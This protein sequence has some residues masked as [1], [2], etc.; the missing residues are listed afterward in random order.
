MGMGLIGVGRKKADGA[1]VGFS[2]SSETE[3]QRNNTNEQIKAADEAAKQQQ[4]GTMTATGA[5]AGAYAG[6]QA[7]S[8]G[9]F[10][11]MAIGAAAGYLFSSLF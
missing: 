4:Q 2:R 9:G 5:M 11:G 1:M 8:V 3:S 7:G 6:A 10:Y